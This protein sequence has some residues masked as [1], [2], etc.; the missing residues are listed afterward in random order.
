MRKTLFVLPVAA[1]L[2]ASCTLQ[3]PVPPLRLPSTPATATATPTSLD[4]ALLTTADMPAGW[5]LS[6]APT[7]AGGT[8]SC[9][10]LDGS[11]WQHLPKETAVTFADGGAELTETLASGT[12]AQAST[13]LADAHAAL[14]GCRTFT[15]T[16]AA[17]VARYTLTPAVAPVYGAESFAFTMVIAGP[18]GTVSG[19][20]VLARTGGTLV[21]II[22]SGPAGVP[23][24][25]VERVTKT[26]VDRAT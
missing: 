19:S 5:T 20:V 24:S 14:E 3:L 6:S 2:L 23:L 22:S 11:A 16:S 8:S 18:H 10:S 26:A 12:V 1:V 9:E 21:Q 25:L 13:S 15:V 4:S 17:G 7:A